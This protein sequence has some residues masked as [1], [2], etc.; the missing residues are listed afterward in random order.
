M[1]RGE[2]NELSDN[3]AFPAIVFLVLLV[4]ASLLLFGAFLNF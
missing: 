3:W 1:N 2:G 4:G